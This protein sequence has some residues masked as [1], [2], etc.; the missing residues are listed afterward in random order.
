MASC[1]KCKDGTAPAPGTEPDG[2]WKCAGAN[3]WSC[4][5]APIS[6]CP[7]CKDGKDDDPDEDDKSSDDKKKKSGG[8]GGKGGCFPA[9]ATVELS[10]GATTSMASLQ[11]GDEVLDAT[12]AYS[13]VY[14]FSHADAVVEAP[15]VELVLE[16]DH[17]IS[18]SP[19]HYIASNGKLLYAKDV[20]LGDKIDYVVD[21][22]TKSG[23]VV[24]TSEVVERGLYN[25]YTLSGS[26]V[27]DGV[28]ASCHS[29]WILDGLL[30][31]RVA[32]VVY[33]RL[34][35]V[36]RL[37]YKMLGPEGMDKVFSVGNTGATASIS[38]QTVMLFGVC[39]FT[40]GAAAAV[41]KAAL[42]AY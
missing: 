6:S 9:A 35:A 27:V 31:P 25:P 22:A 18:L 28:A 32:A 24:K 42:N 36:P 26:I 10:D 7:Q 20:S 21:G 2:G 14:F 29:S 38:E 8:K 34:F 37:A 5:Y 1:P 33:Q 40:I 15:F 41:A 11:L 30:P 13:P 19:D 17:K 12:G 23:A 16:G 3:K 4:P 39:A